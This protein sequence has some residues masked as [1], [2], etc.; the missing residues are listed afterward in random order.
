MS[1]SE[2]RARALDAPALHAAAAGIEQRR[3]AVDQIAGLGGVLAP[4]AEVLPG[5]R[6][7]PGGVQ[8][9]AVQ[10]AFTVPFVL[11]DLTGAR[12]NV[13][14]AEV[15]RTE[16][17][18]LRDR[19]DVEQRAI[20]LWFQRAQSEARLR[21]TDEALTTAAAERA[22]VDAAVAA[23]RD[24]AVDV[25]DFDAWLADLQAAHLDAEGAA[26]EA[27]LALG[28]LLGLDIEVGITSDA[29]VTAS[30]A[31]DDAAVAAARATTASS[32]ALSTITQAA[33]LPTF[34]VGIAAQIDDPNTGF[35]YLR[36]SATLPSLDGNPADRA[37][38]AD[39]TGRARAAEDE[40]RRDRAT[41][42]ARVLHETEHAA[43]KFT[44]IRD[45][46]QPA[47]ERRLALLEA[48]LRFGDGSIRDVLRA[49]RAVI[50]ARITTDVLAL[51][52]ALACALATHSGVDAPACTSPTSSTAPHA[53][54]LP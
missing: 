38:L 34:G 50:D 31:L 41:R 8:N 46:G 30:T 2:V 26:F 27:G 28:R 25:V 16:A 7:A 47:A 37:A 32:E 3:A 43:E 40:T 20:V 51:D 54:E 53:P 11:A 9:P 45:V 19:F 4:S 36:L 21:R 44:L 29:G 13:A 12:R 15:A 14:R 22:A 52:A 33:W 23:G 24:N 1:L 10:A 49:R 5:L 35:A 6:A 18:F 39:A 42:R 48:Q 17:E